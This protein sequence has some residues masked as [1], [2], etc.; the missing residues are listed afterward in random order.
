MSTE[1]KPK[2]AEIRWFLILIVILW[3]YT[4]E[5]GSRINQLHKKIEQLR[6][7]TGIIIAP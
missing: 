6:K 3:V 5:L 2:P 4:L 7:D 1:D